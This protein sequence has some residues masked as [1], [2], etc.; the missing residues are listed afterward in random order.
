VRHG[1]LLAESSVELKKIG[2]AR[3]TQVAVIGLRNHLTKQ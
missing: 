3:E 1:T 2:A